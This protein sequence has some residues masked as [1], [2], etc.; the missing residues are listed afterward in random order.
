MKDA[1]LIILLLAG[2]AFTR[3]LHA[4]PAG[5]DPRPNIIVIMSDD[6]GY[7]DLGCWGGEVET[8]NIDSL[9]KNG[10]RFT[11]FYNSAR[12][13]PTRTTLITGLHPHE[14]GIGLMAREEAP[15]VEA[16][17]AEPAAVEAASTE[18]GPPRRGWWQRTFGD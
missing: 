7:S 18:A 17:A 16:D 13:C 2:A 10:L 8:P 6:M 12:C 4:A 5:N 15:A 14:T 11:Q 3:H 1:L 9:A